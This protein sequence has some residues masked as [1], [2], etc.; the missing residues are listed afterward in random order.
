[1]TDGPVWLTMELVLALH[2]RALASHGGL[3]GIRD[4]GALDS[5]LAR[6]RSAHALGEVDLVGLAAMYGQS[7]AKNHAFLDGNKRVAFLA[8]YTFLGLNGREF[9]A[10]VEDVTRAFRALAS[11]EVSF[12]E[13]TRW[14]EVATRV[15]ESGPPQ[16]SPLPPDS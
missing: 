2:R 10:S 15:R 7:L 13:F 16:S 1:M 14:L 6:P 11:S 3:E 12:E 4:P 5:A 8:T 9:V